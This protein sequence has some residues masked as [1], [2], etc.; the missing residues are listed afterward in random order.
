MSVEASLG[1]MR[2][3][4]KTENGNNKTIEISIRTL[5]TE[6]RGS[7]HPL[8]PIKFKASLSYRTLYLNLQKKTLIPRNSNLYLYL[9][10]GLINS[11][12]IQRKTIESATRWRCYH[13]AVPSFYI[14][15]KQTRLST[16]GQ[17][18]MLKGT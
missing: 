6:T 15:G 9:E 11:Q 2:P 3:C 18:S 12:D 13:Q 1:Y 5:A 10:N 4:C 8:L 7:G 16:L 14:P 17:F